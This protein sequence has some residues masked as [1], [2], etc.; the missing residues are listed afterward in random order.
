M[1]KFREINILA[2]MKCLLHI[3]QLQIACVIG[4]YPE[5]RIKKQLI[6][7]SIT[8]A[9]VP[10]ASDDLVETVDYAAIAQLCRQVAIQGQFQLVES[11]AVA[12][13]Q[14]LH[15]KFNLQQLFVRVTKPGVPCGASETTAEVQHD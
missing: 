5:E 12:L 10:P 1:Q 9:F 11:L 8:Y 15:Q 7:V 6:A 14:A 3:D 4:V 13:F 2:A